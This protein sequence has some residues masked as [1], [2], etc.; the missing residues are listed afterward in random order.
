MIKIDNITLRNL[1]EQVQKNKEDIAAHYN[2]DRVLADFG[3]K[4]IGQVTSAVYLPDPATFTGDYGNA[5]AVGTSE[6]YSFYIWTRADANAGYPNDYWFNIGPLAI[7][8][9]QGPQ[10]LTGATGPKGDNTKWYFGNSFPGGAV[11]GDFLLSSNGNVY[12]LNGDGAQILAINI[13]GPQGVQGIQGIQGPQGPTGETGP[14]GPRGDSGGFINILGIVVSAD[15]LPMPTQLNDL[16]KA[17]LVG[18]AAPYDLY[19]QIGINSESAVWFNAGPLN[20]ATMVTVGG[21]FQNIWDADTKVGFD[22]YAP[23]YSNAT[24]GQ[25]GVIRVGEGLRNTTTGAGHKVTSVSFVDNS[26]LN[27]QAGNST[28]PPSKIAYAVKQSLI[29]PDL[30]TELPANWSTNDKR[31]AQNTLGFLSGEGAPTITTEGYVGQIYTDITNGNQYMCFALGLKG[32]G[33]P[34]GVVTSDCIYQLYA[35]TLNQRMY[36]SDSKADRTK[37]GYTPSTIPYTDE[38]T[39]SWADI[40]RNPAPVGYDKVI[41]V[42]KIV[43]DGSG[44]GEEITLGSEDRCIDFRIGGGLGFRMEGLTKSG[45]DYVAL[46]PYPFNNSRVDKTDLGT[47]EYPFRNLHLSG[48]VLLNGQPMPHV[49]K[50]LLTFDYWGPDT[51]SL[52]T[53]QTYVVVLS[54][55]PDLIERPDIHSDTMTNF[56]NKVFAVDTT[57]RPLID[58]AQTPLIP[59]SLDEDKYLKFLVKVILEICMIFNIYMSRYW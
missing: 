23:L 41:T 16:T 36:I 21:E 11:E 59:L 47:A 26:R 40:F 15:S 12:Y 51:Q 7:V 58:R 8:G 1:F 3:I 45:I 35:D 55:S 49:Y 25:P 31:T 38:Q 50:H 46:K 54:T 37:W 43:G 22:D 33:S 53:Y 34:Q 10:G 6:P 42:N 19:I 32:E 52:G 48:N 20:V 14:Q 5:Y 56:E 27:E 9:P 28:I 24:P 2:V 30:S 18:S 4:I 39:Y 13:K 17:Y 29:N 57:Y 44:A